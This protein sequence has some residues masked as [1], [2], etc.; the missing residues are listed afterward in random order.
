LGTQ[1]CERTTKCA[2][3]SLRKSLLYRGRQGYL[4]LEP[5]APMAGVTLGIGVSVGVTSE[6]G[7]SVTAG[8]SVGTG[9]VGVEVDVEVGRGVGVGVGWIEAPYTIL[10]VCPLVIPVLGRKYGLFNGGMH[11]SAGTV[12]HGYP[13]IIPRPAILSIYR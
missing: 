10:A 3:A 12:P 13:P 4:W 2:L 1:R 9:T 8:V 11:G 6:V 7:V 5:Y